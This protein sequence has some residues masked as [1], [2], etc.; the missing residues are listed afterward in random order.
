MKNIYFCYESKMF[1]YIY[2]LAEIPIVDWG[3]KEPSKIVLYFMK[4][5]ASIL[6]S[7]VEW[8]IFKLLFPGFGPKNYNIV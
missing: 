3:Q 2:I 5:T 6:L 4:V 1:I 7:V 8:N